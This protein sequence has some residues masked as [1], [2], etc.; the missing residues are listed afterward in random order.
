MFNAVRMRRIRY[1]PPNVRVYHA[2][3]KCVDDQ[4]L[5][6]P[7]RRTTFLIASALAKTLEKYDIGLYAAVVMA[8]HFHLVVRA[9]DKVLS[10]AMQFFK[11]RVARALNPLLD[12]QGAMSKERFKDQS[13][14]DDASLM[15][16]VHYVHANP[17][18]AHCVARAQDW[19]GLSSYAAVTEGRDAIEVAYF[20]EDAW[21]AAGRPKRLALFTD[22]VRVPLEKLP[23]WEGLSADALR[24]A[25]GSLRSSMDAAEREMSLTRQK[26]RVRLRSIASLMNADPRIRPAGPRPNTP[27]PWAFGAADAVRALRDA[28]RNMIAFYLKASARFRETGVL[29]E[30]PEGTFPPWVGTRLAPFRP[31]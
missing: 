28:Y 15:Q 18:R 30:F 19:P 7:T 31:H 10:A 3:S 5:W 29:G 22:T 27:P 1:Y 17:V 26:S 21:R 9:E 20:D 6:R 25:H 24:A 13:V 8:N 2:T 12:R 4:F 23:Q 14:L 11:S 16:L